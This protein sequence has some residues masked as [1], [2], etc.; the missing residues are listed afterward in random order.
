VSGI[1]AQ[2]TDPQY[3]PHVLAGLLVATWALAIVTRP[4]GFY[5]PAF[6]GLVIVPLA[7]APYLSAGL[8]LA[9][10]ALGLLV[11]C[12][13]LDQRWLA[14]APARPAPSDGSDAPAG[15]AAGVAAG[16]LYLVGGA[17]LMALSGRGA[18]SWWIGAGTAAHGMLIA[19]TRLRGARDFGPWS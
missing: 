9:L 8:G 17:G 5:R 14:W 13:N 10:L 19:L 15:H 3:F 6:R 18:W 1:L 2:V 4:L 16:V 12:A 11:V 7:V